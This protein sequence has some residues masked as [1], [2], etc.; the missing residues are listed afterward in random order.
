M[1]TSGTK[2]QHI[3]INYKSEHDFFFFCISKADKGVPTL[4]ILRS[5]QIS[6]NFSMPQFYGGTNNYRCGRA[7]P[8][9]VMT[10]MKKTALFK[11]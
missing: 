3:H 2:S 6:L 4:K 8:S 7:C 1:S 9:M 10:D 11:K 5:R